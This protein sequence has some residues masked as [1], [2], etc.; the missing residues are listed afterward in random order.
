MHNSNKA[1]PFDSILGY[2]KIQYKNNAQLAP[3]F[4]VMNAFVGH[5]K[6][7]YDT[8]FMDE[9]RLGNVCQFTNVLAESIYH[10]ICNYLIVPI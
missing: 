9:S 7:I 10:K 6:I 8:S 1:R 2:L 3:V 4:L 5:Y